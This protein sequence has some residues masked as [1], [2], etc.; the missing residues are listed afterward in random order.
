LSRNKTTINI[1]LA[2]FKLRVTVAHEACCVK[3]PVE[4][5][6][7]YD[8]QHELWCKRTG[9]LYYP[10]IISESSS[11]EQNIMNCNIKNV[12]FARLKTYHLW[13]E[14]ERIMFAC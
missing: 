3:E 8:M 9:N 6:I 14:W 2:L 7:G 12:Y 1:N 4:C 11:P 13:K 5:E 10:K